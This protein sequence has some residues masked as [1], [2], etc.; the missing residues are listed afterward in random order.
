MLRGVLGDTDFF[1]GLAAYDRYAYGSVTTSR[2]HGEVSGRDLD[3][4]FQ[5]WIYG[6]Y[7]LLLRLGD[8]STTTAGDEPRP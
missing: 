5:Q 6:D 4:F 2:R 1:A 8:D 3:A 7:H